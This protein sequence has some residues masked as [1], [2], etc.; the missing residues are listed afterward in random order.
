[1]LMLTPSVYLAILNSA[2]KSLGVQTALNVLI[3]LPVNMFPGKGATGSDNFI[4]FL[5]F[6]EEPLYYFI[7]CQNIERV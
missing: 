1:M 4:E 2:V 5:L 6:S 3:S 7:D